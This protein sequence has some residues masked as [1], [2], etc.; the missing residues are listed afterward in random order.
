MARVQAADLA[1]TA[2]SR[3]LALSVE[4]PAFPHAVLY[5][6]LAGSLAAAAAAKKDAPGAGAGAAGAAGAPLGPAGMVGGGGGGPVHDIDGGA[7]DTLLVIED[8]EVRPGRGGR[9]ACTLP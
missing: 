8:S 5:Q 3:D 1:G 4:L 9:S 6:Q 7:L 2:A